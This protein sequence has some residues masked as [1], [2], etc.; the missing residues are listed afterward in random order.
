MFVFL[1]QKTV[2]WKIVLESGWVIV[3][4]AEFGRDFRVMTKPDCRMKCCVE[5]SI[6]IYQ[7]IRRAVKEER[8]MS[9]VIPKRS[10]IC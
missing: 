4:F 2:L 10:I 3:G 7:G 9:P 1:Y 6:G 5:K 8:N